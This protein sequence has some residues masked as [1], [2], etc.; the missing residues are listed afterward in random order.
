MRARHR[1]SIFVLPGAW[2][3]VAGVLAAPLAAAPAQQGPTDLTSQARAVA[4]PAK[5]KPRLPANPTVGASAKPTLRPAVKKAA[6]TPAGTVPA[7][8]PAAAGVDSAFEVELP[9]SLPVAHWTVDDAKALL[10]AIRNVGAEGLF[11]RD[12]QPAALA[13]QIA[14]GESPDLDTLASHLFVWLAEDLRDGRTPMPARE[15]RCGYSG[16][17]KAGK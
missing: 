4:M 5:P 14:A 11:P 9:E 2:L 3:V 13:T 16:R 7:A 6:A 15:Q 1:T 17:C 10:V 8:G 12:Y